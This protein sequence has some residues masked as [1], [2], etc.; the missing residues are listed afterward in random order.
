M[1]TYARVALA[2]KSRQVCFDISKKCLIPV[3]SWP[4]QVWPSCLYTDKNLSTETNLQRNCHPASEQDFLPTTKRSPVIKLS[5]NLVILKKCSPHTPP[6]AHQFGMFSTECFRCLGDQLS[7]ILM[8]RKTVTTVKIKGP[9][10]LSPFT[11]HCT[12]QGNSC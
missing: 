12:L 8:K 3:I 1:S 9:A 6:F 2:T 10:E 5:I 7:R 4:R 11:G